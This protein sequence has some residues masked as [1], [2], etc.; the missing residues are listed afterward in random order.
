MK[1]QNNTKKKKKK[2]NK[3]KA[4]KTF[5]SP[6]KQLMLPFGRLN[7]SLNLYYLTDGHL[8]FFFLSMTTS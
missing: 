2:T 5:N 6:N 8:Y 7:N 3:K 1:K 4:N